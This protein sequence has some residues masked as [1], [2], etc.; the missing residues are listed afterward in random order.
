MQGATITL[1]FN[2]NDED[3]VD[4]VDLLEE[5]EYD[6]TVQEVREFP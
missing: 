3:Y 6:V 5:S 4:F 2:G 1:D